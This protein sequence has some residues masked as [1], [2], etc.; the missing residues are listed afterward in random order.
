MISVDLHE[1]E[2]SEMKGAGEVVLQE[3][4]LGEGLVV[5]VVG[6]MMIIMVG[7]VGNGQEGRTKRTSSQITWTTSCPRMILS[8]P[9]P[10]LLGTWS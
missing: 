8:P 6:F 3:A 1:E 9:G 2:T 10:C 7:L 5:V 4:L